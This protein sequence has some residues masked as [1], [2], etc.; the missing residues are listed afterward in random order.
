M[1][2]AGEV[3]DDEIVAMYHACDLFVLP[4]VTRA[5]AFGVVQLEAMA[6]GKPV[7]STLLPSGVPWVNQDGRTGLVVTPWDVVALRNALNR[8]ASEPG[9]RLNMGTAGRLRVL[10]EFS[11]DQMIERM[12]ALVHA[13]HRGDG[14]ETAARGLQPALEHQDIRRQ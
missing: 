14:P 1:A 4:S 12:T 6:C 3:S 13:T 8:L 9:L 2:F 11:I 10:Q 7:I 5:E